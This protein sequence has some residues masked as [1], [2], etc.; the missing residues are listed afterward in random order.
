LIRRTLL[1]ALCL[2]VPLS[3]LSAHGLRARLNTASAFQKESSE[4]QFSLSLTLFSTLAAIN[5]AGYDA[6]MD[7]PLNAQYPLRTQIRDILAK[8]NI[9]C[10]P[11]L[12][13]FYREHRKGTETADFAQYV[14]FALVAGDA[15]KFEVPAQ[16]PPDVESLRGFSDLLARFYKQADLESLWNRSQN[17]Y[18]AAIA[19]Y[20]DPVI[21]AIFEANGYLRNPSGFLGRRF[22]IYL[23]L[24]GAPDQ[25]QVRSYRSDYFVVVT[26]ASTPA[27]DEIRDAY[28]AYILDPLTFKYSTVI[29]EKQSLQKFAQDAPALDLAYKDDFALLV[30]KC[31]IKAIDSRLMHGG[32]AARDAFV[33]QA[34]RDGYILT[35]A[36]AELLPKYEKQQDAFRLYYPDL[37]AAVDVKKEQKRLKTVEFAQSAAPRVI[38]PPAKLELPPAE[39]TLESAEGVYE[40]GD[41]ENAKKLFKKVFEQTTDKSMQGRAY[42]GL[43]RIAVHENEKDQAVELFKRTADDNPNPAITAWAHVYLGRLAMAAGNPDNATTQFKLA[44]SIDGASAMAREAAQNGLK[45]TSSTGDK[46]Q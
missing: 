21:G 12:K 37:I 36:F 19:R 29:K 20:Q 18:M 30:T 14:S 43:A 39:Q 16:A 45:S 38:A 46:Q 27:V 4:S 13:D 17:A 44:L 33:N 32:E 25:V 31:L 7:S 23:D 2:S 6:G 9:P 15:P 26:P 11:E 42:Y 3:I 41:Y 35:A 1:V 8:R 22:Q 10:L 5:A 28:L 24:L 34:M 40:Q